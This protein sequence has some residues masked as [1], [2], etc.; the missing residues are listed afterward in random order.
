MPV[1]IRPQGLPTS[2][3]YNVMANKSIKPVKPA[4]L[5]QEERKEQ[6]L[7]FIAQKRNEIYTGALFNIIQGRGPLSEQEATA[8]VES[9]KTLADKSVAVLFNIPADGA[10]E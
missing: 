2:K 6:V 9:A 3:P 5:T 1:R 10:A 8:A 4:A 7:R